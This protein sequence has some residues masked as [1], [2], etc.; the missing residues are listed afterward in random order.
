[1]S[2]RRSADSVVRDECIPCIAASHRHRNAHVID[3]TPPRHRSCGLLFRPIV[4]YIIHVSP[5][6]RRDIAN[7]AALT[8]A[9]GHGRRLFPE[10]ALPAPAETNEGWDESHAGDGKT[11]R[12]FQLRR[13]ALLRGKRMADR[14]RRGRRQG[15]RAGFRASHNLGRS[16]LRIGPSSPRHA[17]RRRRG[18]SRIHPRQRYG[19]GIPGARLGADRHRLL[20]G[21][22]P[23]KLHEGPR[24]RA[25][26]A[27]R[28]SSR[29]PVEF[30][31][32]GFRAPLLR[33]EVRYVFLRQ[34]RRSRT[35]DA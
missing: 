12:F 19:V 28:R 4:D 25:R 1:M 16:A 2:V 23:R 30:H 14:R 6:K 9:Y 31:A 33:R 26:V 34:H 3:S 11:Q 13:N 20:E 7:R 32:R 29:H 35:T 15:E 21:A 18:L 27:E 10:Y 24:T 17:G 5:G 8:Q 22:L